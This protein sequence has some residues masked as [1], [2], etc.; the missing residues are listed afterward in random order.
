[1]DTQLPIEQRQTDQNPVSPKLFGFKPT[2]THLIFLSLV[3]LAVVL[4]IILAVFSI[5]S[6]KQI[7]EIIPGGEKK[8]VYSK[9]PVPL[10]NYDKKIQT[11][12][13]SC[14]TIASICASATYKEN[15]LSG[16]IPSGSPIYAA[17]NG[18]ATVL[19]PIHPNTDGTKE[20]FNSIV[21]INKDKGLIAL[22]SFKGKTIDNKEV[23][24]GERIATGSGEAIKF[25]E[26]KSFI[27]ELLKYQ[28]KGATK[29]ALAS[30][31]FKR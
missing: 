11:G 27:F 23:K 19:Y 26:N 6:K 17:F 25:K 24:E 16:N 20:S 13:F 29:S 7:T 30:K 2:R 21:L 28:E 22:Y 10:K 4:T 31:D 8:V 15:T 1:M 5:L 3:V 14:P 9:P 18:T 12:P